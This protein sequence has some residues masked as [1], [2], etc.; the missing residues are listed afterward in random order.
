MSA[1]QVYGTVRSYLDALVTRADFARFYAE[2]VTLEGP[3]YG[4]S[5]QGA[6]EVEE[7]I[8]SHYEVEFDSHPQVV[9]IIAD[10]QAA[11]AE[12]IFQGR[13]TGV[14][15]GEPPTGNEVRLPISLFFEVQ[16]ATITAMRVYYSWDELMR[17]VRG[18]DSG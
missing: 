6:A 9:S 2:D 5:V 7:G 18:E 3:G 1:Q 11:A 8:R 12:L 14:L 10:D 17:Q 16:S 15:D 13:N 4:W